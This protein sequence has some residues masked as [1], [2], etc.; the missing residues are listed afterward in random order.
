MFRIMDVSLDHPRQEEAGKTSQVNARGGN[1]SK[2]PK[3]VGKSDIAKGQGQKKSQGVTFILGKDLGVADH[4]SETISNVVSNPGM[5][6][7]RNESR[8]KS[9]IQNS[10][11]VYEKYSM[12]LNRPADDQKILLEL[13]ERDKR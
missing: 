4:Q 6:A 8:D 13:A 10:A 7:Q 11:R 2:D 1:G 12:H 5:L 3:K 9:G